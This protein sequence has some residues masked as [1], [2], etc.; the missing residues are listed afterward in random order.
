MNEMQINGILN[1]MEEA[2]THVPLAEKMR[3]TKLEDVVGQE[4][5]IG[6][7][8]LIGPDVHARNL[9]SLILWGP[10]GVGKTTI[11]RILAVQTNA[12]FIE[13]SA[14]HAGKADMLKAVNHAK[15]YGQLGQRT[16]LFVDE[17][18]RFNKAQQDFL[19]PYVED[20]TVILIGATTENPSFEVITPLLS[21]SSVVTLKPLSTEAIKSLLTRAK[22]H[23][24]GRVLPEQSLQL[25]ADMAGGDAR[26]A[27]NTLELASSLAKK[28]ITL[29]AV[30]AAAQQS[31]LAYDKTGEEHYNTISAFIKS[32]RGSDTD[33]SLFYL[34]K[35]LAS[36]EDPKF[37]ARR[38]LIF[39]SEDVGM[40]SPHV[41]TFA[42]SVFQAV[43]RVGMPEAE[44]ILSHGAVALA[45][46]KKSRAVADAMYGAKQALAK[47]PHVRV[48]LH[49]RNAPTKL[50]EELGY[51]KA[52]EW[53]AGFKHG[54]G[55]MPPELADE[56]FY[57]EKD[58]D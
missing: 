19:L 37:I 33:A 18:H 40:A 2:R 42:V 35:M 13:L 3:P 6:A 39:A 55:F 58:K 4:H 50:M 1:L 53:K 28:T 25:I 31:G 15:V 8:K 23:I 45:Q 41:L 7:G 49:L 30:E 32:M 10:P 34:H 36:G 14:V 5:V 29:K 38:M 26:R 27:L 54:E 48:P 24:K 44:Y 22:P 20:G 9:N 56:H 43:E 21:R 51:G 16:V 57:E 12:Q 11:A 47:H 52:Y 17:I 46:S